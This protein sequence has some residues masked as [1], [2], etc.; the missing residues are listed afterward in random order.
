LYSSRDTVN[1]I[2]DTT[3]R[4][5]QQ[6]NDEID[7]ARP[8]P[9][10]FLCIA[11]IP[12]IIDNKANNAKGIDKTKSS[13]GTH[14]GTLLIKLVIPPPRARTKTQQSA[15]TPE[16]IFRIPAVTGRHDFSISYLLSF[17]FNIYNYI[18]KSR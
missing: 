18:L 6:N 15:H 2:I 16:T 5:K 4:R 12:P 14:W 11:Q 1:R 9:Q 13:V 7:P 17:L 10:C 8:H 3:P